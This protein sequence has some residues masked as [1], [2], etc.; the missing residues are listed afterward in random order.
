VVLLVS[1]IRVCVTPDRFGTIGSRCGTIFIGP[2]AYLMGPFQRSVGSIS[3]K[4][5]VV[6]HAGRCWA[7]IGTF[8][9]EMVPLI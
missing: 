7:F 9:A 2:Y 6:P 1:N 4:K 3:S 8:E 5:A